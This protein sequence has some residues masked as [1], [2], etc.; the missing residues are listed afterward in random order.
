MALQILQPLIYAF[1]VLRCVMASIV[2]AEHAI[3]QTIAL[4]LS[5]V[6]PVY[7]T[8]A[9]LFTA[10]HCRMLL[11]LAGYGWIQVEMVTKKKTRGS[12]LQEKWSPKAGDVIVSNWCSW[13]EILWL[14][15]RFNPV[16][17]LP[18]A[19]TPQ[20]GESDASTATGR[21]TGTG[22]AAIHKSSN[23]QRTAI[24]GFHHVSLFK[25]LSLLGKT[26]STFGLPLEGARSLE[27]IR[28]SA[29]RPIVVFPECTTSNGRGL[30]RFAEVFDSSITVPV[31]GFNVFIMCGRFDSP[32]HWQ[33]SPTCS[34]PSSIPI[35]L[36]QPLV[37]ILTI[38]F[39]P[40]RLT[41]RLL[42]PSESPSTGTFLES[43]VLAA[44]GT[45]ATLSEACAILISQLGKLKRTG[46]GWE[47]KTS[48]LSFYYS[49]R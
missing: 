16:F 41:I 7:R 42:A 17:V 39:E 49:K 48:F 19:P 9:W 47:E 29:D 12:Q 27:S 30:L 4:V 43:D 45:K 2:L 33:P 23:M 3:L 18:V 26:P 20:S 34:I 37:H 35:P 13:A 28:K 8:V 14:A 1:A 22:S 40:S 31:K 11:A 15:F 10:V 25:I 38:P 6:P 24:T 32:T 46:Q 5:P 44:G 21:R 36:P